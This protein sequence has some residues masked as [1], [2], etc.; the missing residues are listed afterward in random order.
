MILFFS[1]F[2]A[3]LRFEIKLAFVLC[4]T[5]SGWLIALPQP[6]FGLSLCN[7]TMAL[8]FVAGHSIVPV[9]TSLHLLLIS[10]LIIC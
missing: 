10:L 4:G 8:I 2:R 3:V 7:I 5:S 1:S 6:A 9:F